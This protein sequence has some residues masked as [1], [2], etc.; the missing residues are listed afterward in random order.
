[1]KDP[2]FCHKQHDFL[3]FKLC[4]YILGN[5]DTEMESAAGTKRR[6]VAGQAKE[7]QAVGRE[8]RRNC[9]ENL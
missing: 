3:L 8:Q 6:G 9:G 4:E 7:K 2:M 5:M 1:M